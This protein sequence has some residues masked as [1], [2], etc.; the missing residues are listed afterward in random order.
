MSAPMNSLA[1]GTAALLLAVATAADAQVQPPAFPTAPGGVVQPAPRDA[2]FESW[3]AARVSATQRLPRLLASRSASLVVATNAERYLPDLTANL[4]RAVGRCRD[5]LGLSD[6]VIES[7]SARRPW[8]PFDAA[9]R[10]PALILTLQAEPGASVPDCITDA[11]DRIALAE[12]AI[13]LDGGLP[14]A[15]ALNSAVLRVDGR[16]VQPLQVGRVPV[17]TLSASQAEGVPQWQ[18]RLYVALD[19]IAPRPDGTWPTI[20]LEVYREDGS[21]DAVAVSS[22]AIAAVLRDAMP[23]AIARAAPAAS[24]RWV[25]H[26]RM[27]NPILQQAAA[28]RSGEGASARIAALFDTLRAGSVRPSRDELASR[29]VVGEWLAAGGDSAGARLLAADVRGGAACVRIS[30]ESGS[31]LAPFLSNVPDTP[32]C[33]F[34]GRRRALLNSVVLPGFGQASQ[35]YSALR[36]AIGIAFFAG[37]VSQFG[38]ALGKQSE[39]QDA[40]DSYR[41]AT[42]QTLADQRFAIAEDLRLKSRDLAMTGIYIWALSAAE[43]YWY[44]SRRRSRLASL[45]TYGQPAAVRVGLIPTPTGALG[46]GVSITH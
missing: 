39:A 44:E 13:S 25:E 21:A 8:A 9:M 15:P 42:T 28:N 12:A 20:A 37:S 31:P 36:R 43:N 16:V 14:S 29:I 5:V 46:V 23:W 32:A 4:L 19:E 38:S 33:E 40:Y 45:T 18:L 24:T 11:V 6:Q 1:C 26:P 34:M 10:G 7:S 2:G 22:S 27:S 30:P 41:A 3:R 35:R 17:R